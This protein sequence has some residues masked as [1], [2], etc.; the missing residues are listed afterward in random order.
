MKLR[1]RRDD[2]VN[3]DVNNFKKLVEVGKVYVGHFCIIFATLTVNLKLF[4]N[5]NLKKVT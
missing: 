2:C 3:N 1:I 4:Q 5:A